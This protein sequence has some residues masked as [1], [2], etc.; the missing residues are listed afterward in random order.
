MKMSD[1]T[2]LTNDY[3]ALVCALTLAVLA[4]DKGKATKCLKMA[5]GF[6]AGLDEFSIARAQ[7]EARAETEEMVE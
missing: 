4:P 5:I 6:A 7:K 1:G 3:N 2:E